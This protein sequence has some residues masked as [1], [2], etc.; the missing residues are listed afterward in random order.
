MRRM[1]VR[2]RVL[3]T[4]LKWPK[5]DFLPSLDRNSLF[6]SLEV[7]SV[8]ADDERRRQRRTLDRSITPDVTI[9]QRFRFKFWPR[10]SHV[11]HPLPPSL[12]LLV[13]TDSERL[14]EYPEP[15]QLRLV[16]LKVR[17]Q[18]GTAGTF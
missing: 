12:P 9:L 15:A 18:G 6:L 11:A 5:I 16:R 17:H 4:R 14:N 13:Y 2:W 7:S 10:E 3:S 8:S 1:P